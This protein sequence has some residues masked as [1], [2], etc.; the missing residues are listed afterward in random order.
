MKYLIVV[1]LSLLAANGLG[2]EARAQF[3]DACN[4]DGGDQMGCTPCPC[5]NEA[6]VG[7]VGGCLNSAVTAGRIKGSGSIR[8]SSNDMRFEGCALTPSSFAVLVSGCNLAPDN[9]ANPCF[10]MDSGVQSV[11]LDGL[12][13]AVFN[14]LRHGS[15]ASDANGDVGVTNNGWGDPDPF[16]GFNMFVAGDTKYFQIFYRETPGTVCMTQQN[17]SQAICVTFTP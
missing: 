2:G 4:G 14:T 1:M 13:C 8:I 17:T 7:T 9:P 12:R 10:G 11:F 6:P 5:A 3:I 15:R 16:P